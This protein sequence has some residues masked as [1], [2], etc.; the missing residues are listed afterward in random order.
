MKKYKVIT[1]SLDFIGYSRGQV[2]FMDNDTESD[3]MSVFNEIVS[4]GNPS[5]TN[6]FT[7][8]K[9]AMELH[10][11]WFEEVKVAPKEY[12]KEDMIAFGD[13]VCNSD[14]EHLV[15]NKI[16]VFHRWLKTKS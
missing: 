14:M 10:G 11:D 16:A 2:F 13:F 3:I 9:R 5:D 6:R 15:H 12:T 4:L 7:L 8:I 1:D